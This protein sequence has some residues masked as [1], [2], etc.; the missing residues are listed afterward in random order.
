MMAS[1]QVAMGTY[2]FFDFG[3]V[4]WN[5]LLAV[6]KFSMYWPKTWF[7]GHGYLLFL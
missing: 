4:D 3:E 5:T 7:S 6:I 2:F 1:L